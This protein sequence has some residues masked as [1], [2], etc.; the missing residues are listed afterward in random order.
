MIIIK[1]RE[2]QKKIGITARVE[3]IFN[4]GTLPNSEKI[5]LTLKIKLDQYIASNFSIVLLDI[6]KKVKKSIN[7]AKVSRALCA[8]DNQTC[9]RFLAIFVHYYIINKYYDELQFI[10]NNKT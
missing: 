10:F 3:I 6:Y 4:L 1:H 8:I 5:F 9:V 2:S 7:K